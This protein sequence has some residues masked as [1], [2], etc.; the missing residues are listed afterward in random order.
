MSSSVYHWLFQRVTAF[1][2]LPFSL[3]FFYK[4]LRFVSIICRSVSEL[5]LSFL[6]LQTVDLIV[7]MCFFIIAFYHAVLGLQVILED[8][9]QLSV[10][11]V[12]ILVLI[13]GI[14][15]VTLLFLVVAVFNMLLNF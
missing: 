2:L 6:E 1:V 7:L 15:I 4:F 11:R 9:V 12:F 14:V 8:Y 5:D 10:L 13:N 3:W